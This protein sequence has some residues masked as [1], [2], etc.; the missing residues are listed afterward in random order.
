MHLSEYFYDKYSC[1][2]LFCEGNCNDTVGVF[3]FLDH[4]SF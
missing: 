4:I 3:I 2:R 1:Q